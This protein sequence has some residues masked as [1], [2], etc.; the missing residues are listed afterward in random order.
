MT[1]LMR[2]TAMLIG[3]ATLH[4]AASA[5]VKIG[6]PAPNFTM[7]TLDGSKV[8][9]ADL[10]GQVIVLNFWATWC[11]PCKRELPV[12][13]AFYRAAQPHGLRVFAVT[14]ENSVPLS[15]LEPLTKLLAITT[16]RKI[17]GPYAPIDGAVPTNFVIDRQ[18]V[19]RYAKAAAFDLDALNATLVPLLNA[20]APPPPP[21]TTLAATR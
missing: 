9:L 20:P 17:S 19:V 6:D 14:T 13:D 5:R 12:L 1:R 8:T 2:T 16:I 4:A 3:A 21:P 18:G 15:R 10:R 7:R 11:G